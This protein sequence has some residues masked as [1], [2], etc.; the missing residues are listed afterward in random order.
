MQQRV[1]QC[2]WCSLD[3][4]GPGALN[5]GMIIRPVEPSDFDQWLPLWD[6]YNAFYGREGETA[7]PRTVTD[8]TRARFFAA[9]EP[10]Q[11][12]VAESEGQLIGLAHYIFHRS[13]TT[14]ADTCYLQ[15]LFTAPQ[16]RGQGTGRALIEAVAE[17]ARDHGCSR[18]YWHTHHSNAQARRLYDV[19]GRDS[20]F[21]VYRHD[22]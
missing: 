17:K 13:T 2:V 11:C 22:L 21:I 6:G 3:D 18:L 19:V 10:V 12:L 1:T 7:L 15:D 8:I 14:I 16:A 9:G 5:R 4:D 20:G